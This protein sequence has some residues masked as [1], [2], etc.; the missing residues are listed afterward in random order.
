[1][2]RVLNCINERTAENFIHDEEEELTGVE[3][4][5]ES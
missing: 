1:M 5:Y 3:F 2:T 4:Q